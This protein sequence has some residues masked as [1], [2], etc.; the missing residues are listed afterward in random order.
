MRV[1]PDGEAA[2]EGRALRDDYRVT[3]S[4]RENESGFVRFGWEQGRK[5]YDDSGG[6][7]AG[8][9]PS[10]YSLGRDLYLD[11]GRLWTE[12]GLRRPDW[13][14]I[15]VGYEYQTREGEE[16]TLQWGAV[17][18]QGDLTRN[19]FPNSKQV[20]EHTHVVKL[21]VVHDLAGYRVSDSFRGE[22]YDL[23]TKRRNTTP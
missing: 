6:Y 21:D 19:I 18:G 3:L 13:P 22:F 20:D 5:Y 23:S 16:S 4:L 1:E 2:L 14:E 11:R 8:F 10:L 9:Q 7:Y 15:T 12:L 17:T